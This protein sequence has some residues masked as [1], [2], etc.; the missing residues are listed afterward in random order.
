MYT[1]YHNFIISIFSVSIFK[2]ENDSKLV[3]LVNEILPIVINLLEDENMIVRETSDSVLFK[4]F[5]TVPFSSLQ[6][7]IVKKLI[8]F[9][10]DCLDKYTSVA[11][12]ICW[13]FSSLS[14]S[15]FEAQKLLSDETDYPSTYFLS[16][17][18]EKIVYKLLDIA[19]RS[20]PQKDELISAAFKAVADFVHNSP[21]DCYETVI[22]IFQFVSNHINAFLERKVQAGS[23][24]SNSQFIE[25]H[26]GF[27]RILKNIIRR[28]KKDDLMNHADDLM[29]F[30]L[31]ILR[32]FNE[33]PDMLVNAI[34]TIETFIEVNENGFVRYL[35]HFEPLLLSCL[36]NKNNFQVSL[37][38]INSLEL[39]MRACMK[40]ESFCDNVM[41]TL[42]NNLADVEVNEKVKLE[43]CLEFALIASAIRSNFRRFAPT[44]IT[45]I[46]QIIA[47]K[48]QLSF[49]AGF[50]YWLEIRNKCIQGLTDIILSCYSNKNSVQQDQLS[51]CYIEMILKSIE[52]V[53]SEP[54]PEDK[55]MQI[56]IKLIDAICS[57][58][59]I[60]Y[61]I[62]LKNLLE[63]NPALVKLF[64]LSYASKIPLTK[65]CAQNC[66]EK[67]HQRFQF[68][69]LQP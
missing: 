22:K 10:F 67:I 32:D 63:G 11:T 39:V 5:Y 64:Q 37:A 48:N 34:A 60:C 21:N 62:L 20:D 8:P 17:S 33:A 47:S 43:I 15:T 4:C 14:E 45:S 53:T 23:S 19:E 26:S 58:F 24:N 56:C 50:E 55:L 16:E 31:T 7:E 6:E 66:I 54:L 13:A 38:A 36:Q 30:L 40:K 59:G 44:V 1:S 12:E 57:C 2:S 28:F 29:T 52:A 61:R 9:M 41:T 18:Y 27:F 65:E 35:E 46:L 69:I 51:I 68:N 49:S 3:D 42:L 25:I